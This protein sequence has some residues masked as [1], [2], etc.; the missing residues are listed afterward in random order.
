MQRKLLVAALASSVAT[1]SRSE[2]DHITLLPRPKRLTELK[3]TLRKA[4]MM[5]PSSRIVEDV[6]RYP[7]AIDA[8]IKH[9]GGRRRSRLLRPTHWL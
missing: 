1:A 4:Y 8:V 9:K 7:V 6:M 3:K 2:R 5:L